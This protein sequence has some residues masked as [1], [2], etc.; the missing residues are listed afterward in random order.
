LSSSF[1]VIKMEPAHH[2][3]QAVRAGWAEEIDRAVDNVKRTQ[4][5]KWMRREWHKADSRRQWS[6]DRKARWLEWR[7][8][9]SSGPTRVEAGQ[10][11][12]VSVTPRK[13]WVRGRVPKEFP[14]WT[15]RHWSHDNETR[16]MLSGCCFEV[17]ERRGGNE[18]G[19]GKATRAV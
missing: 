11:E 17:S 12:R 9:R 8:R 4:A 3:E 13:V 6:A 16:A 2:A 15:E 7:E 14:D 18:G 1:M 19:A 5:D 10:P